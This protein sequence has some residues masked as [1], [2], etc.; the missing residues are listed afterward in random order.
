MGFKRGYSGTILPFTGIATDEVWLIRAEA[1][2][3][4]GQWQAAMADLN[5]LLQ[6][7]WRTGTFVPLTALNATDALEKSEQKEE[8]NWF[9]A[10]TVGPTLNGTIKKGPM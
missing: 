6:K 10:A 8:K 4:T 3:K 7:R 2:A 5:T 9:G 1:L